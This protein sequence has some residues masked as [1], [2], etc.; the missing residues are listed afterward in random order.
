MRTVPLI[1]FRQRGQCSRAEKKININA[2]ILVT[3]FDQNI[4]VYLPRIGHKSQC[5]HKEYMQLTL[6]RQDI[7]CRGELLSGDESPL[8]KFGLQQI[9]VGQINYFKM[10]EMNTLL[11]ST[12][13]VD[14]PHGADTSRAQLCS[15]I[16]SGFSGLL[17]VSISRCEIGVSDLISET[18][19][20]IGT[21]SLVFVLCSSLGELPVARETGSSTRV[22]PVD[23][24]RRREEEGT[25]DGQSTSS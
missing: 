7:L 3:L 6:P 2:K 4:V 13:C 14:V 23:V 10:L 12:D 20:T 21:F 24:T 19:G 17:R 22:Y 1:F 9:N 8:P 25:A 18:N 15:V 5:V 16:F 11:L